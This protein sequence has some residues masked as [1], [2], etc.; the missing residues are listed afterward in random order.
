[1]KNTIGSWLKEWSMRNQIENFKCK[2]SRTHDQWIRLIF[3]FKVLLL[4]IE[5]E[6]VKLESA[7][8]YVLTDYGWESYTVFAD[9]LDLK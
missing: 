8:W 9:R 3:Q 5:V 1:M 6:A 4:G 7:R 2:L